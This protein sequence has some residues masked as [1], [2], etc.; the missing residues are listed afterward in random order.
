MTGCLPSSLLAGWHVW[1]YVALQLC[2]S[3]WWRTDFWVL[4]SWWRSKWIR[5]RYIWCWRYTSNLTKI[6]WKSSSC[7]V[8]CWY[9]SLKAF[10]LLIWEN[11]D[12]DGPKNMFESRSVTNSSLHDR[13]ELLQRAEESYYRNDLPDKQ[14]DILFFP[15]QSLCVDSIL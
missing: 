6:F 1:M 4:E 5:R 3:P 10:L 14:V 2:K 13:I 8:M 7:V 15:S 9:R 12:V 11:L